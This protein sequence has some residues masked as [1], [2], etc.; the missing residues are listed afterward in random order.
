MLAKLRVILGEVLSHSARVSILIDNLDKAWN[1]NTDLPLLSDLLFG[2]L[3][4]SQRIA[5]E[6]WQDGSGK[7]PVNLYFTLFLRS[8]IFAA[9]L[10]FAKER[11]KL[12]VRLL[13]WRDPALLKRVVEQRFMKSDANIEVPQQVWERYFP[14]AIG[15]VPTW[16]YIGKRI[17]PR[18]RDII[19]LIKSALQIS[20][21]RGRTRVEDA[22]LI[23]GE[24]PYSR[25]ALD[26]LIVE[27]AARI[28]NIEDLIL[29][30]IESREIVSE[31][32]ISDRLLAA[33]MPAGELQSVITLL[34]ELTFLGFEVAHNRFEFLY[35][36]QEERKMSTM[37]RKTADETTNG[38]RRFLIHPAFHAFLEIKPQD[39]TLP[40]GQATFNL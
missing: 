12:P 34:V 8:D 24:K 40:T 3:S 2:L 11:D 16:E 19:Y 33:R 27:A 37:A 30:F 39:S 21:N 13:I 31:D 9:M 7:A 25:F 17:H 1:P 18:P 5:E 4:V 10:Q 6:F 38:V 14:A 28:A 32:E 20:V 22:D 15:G 29:Q 23:D 26:S 36:E 35:D